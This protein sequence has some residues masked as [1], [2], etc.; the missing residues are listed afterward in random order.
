MLPRVRI[1]YANG[2]LGQVAAMADGCLGMM[3][4]GAKEVTGDDKFKLGKAYTLRKLADLE[5]LGV[6][7]ENNPN[8]YRNVKEFYA[9]AGDGTELWLTGYAE[10]ET[11]ANAFDKDNAAGAV[12]L[13]K[14]SNGKIRGLVAFK[15]PAEAYELTTT[16]GLD[17]D[18]FAALPKAQQLGDWATDTLRAPIFSLVEGYGYAGDPAALKDLTET[19]YNRAGVVL[20][21]TA[22]SSKNAAM[23][24]VAG[25]IAASAVQ[26]KISRVRDG[27]LQPLTFYV[28]AEPAELADLETINDKGYITFRTFVGKAGYFIT[29]DN[30]ATTPEDD[31]RALTNR[32]V[33]DKAYRIAYAQLVEWLNDGGSG[34]EVR[35]SGS[36]LVLD[37]RSRRR[38]GHR[39]ADDRTGQLGQRSV[40]FVRYGRGVQ[41]RLR[42]EH[43]GHF[44]GKDRAAR[45]AQRICKV[46][47]RGAW[48]QNR[49][50]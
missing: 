10:S 43:S 11:F 49:I 47:R 13:L 6:T 22:A 9:E 45:Q 14:A 44:A 32:R 16:E 8:L 50:K 17:A 1:N 38:A 23:G 29:D 5:A 18:V 41:D 20:G 48:V 40:G 35:H 19:E 39:D 3:A 31:Y 27:A 46:Y 33:I 42:P 7:S 34:L 30:L 36:R 15:T 24:V 25:R 37:R 12:A 2:T 21:D 26:R 28:G 4:L